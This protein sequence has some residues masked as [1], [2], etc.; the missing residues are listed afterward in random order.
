MNKIK[1]WFM[2]L[3]LWGLMGILFILALIV[4][5]IVTYFPASLAEHIGGWT[6]VAIITALAGGMIFN[7]IRGWIRGKN[8]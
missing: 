6:M 2:K 1:N 5:V 4:K 3:S 7:L 8:K